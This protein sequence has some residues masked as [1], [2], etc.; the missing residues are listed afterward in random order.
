M[1][2][3]RRP[4]RIALAIVPALAL[5]ACGL[6]TASTTS[7]PA[8][9]TKVIPDL[10]PN[11]K[12]SITFESYNLSTAGPWTD[13]FNQLIA[14][15]E[16]MYPNITVTAQKPG[17]ATA[18]GVT[19]AISSLQTEVAAGNAPDVAQET[20]GDM[21]FVVN[22]LKAQPLDDLVGKQAVQANFGGTYPYAPSAETL[23]DVGGKTYGVPFVFSTPVLYYNASL[24]KAAGLDPT[25]PPTTWAQVKTDALAI[26]SHTGKDGAYVDCL[27][28]VAGDWCYQALV[29]SNG[30]SVISTDQSKLTFANPPAVQAVAMAQDLVDSG[31]SPKLTQVQAYPEFAAGNMGMILE[32]SS[33]QGTFQ[34]GAAAADWQ[35]SDAVMPSFNGK[36]TAPTNSGAAL[37]V[38][39]T[40]PAKQRASWDL[41]KYL[42]SNPAFTLIASK[43]G[44]LPL[45]TGLVNDPTGLQGWAK[46][47]PLLQPNLDQL[48]RLHQWVS[49]PGDN[50][51]QIRN[52]MLQAVEKVVYQNAD[53]ASTLAAAQQEATTLM[54]SA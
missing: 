42:T 29:G 9:T 52:D 37:F 20:F 25:R 49:F 27:T 35:L 48:A 28:Q 36:T 15:F 18:N 45:R 40:D 50:Y 24:F 12:V 46:Q 11:Q 14:N 13:T 32:S 17:G 19:N 47:N 22:K 10:R 16:K 31:A 6:G 2:R 8:T 41:I 5:A 53:P 39:S 21:D 51:V 33:L 54:P 34:K 7:S 3:I 1:K 30:G 4:V 43:I 26:K 23:G 38:M 44:Y